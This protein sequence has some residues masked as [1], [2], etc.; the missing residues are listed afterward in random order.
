MPMSARMTCLRFAMFAVLAAGGTSARADPYRDGLAAWVKGDFVTAVRI[1]TPLADNGDPAAQTVLGGAYVDGW[2]VEKDCAKGL[3]LLS[4][5]A[6]AGARHAEYLM[7]RLSATGTCVTKSDEDALFHYK[8]AAAKHDPDAEFEIGNFYMTG[9][10]APLD[11]IEAH[12]WLTLCVRD[13]KD[14]PSYSRKHVDT[15][16]HILDQLD[17]F[18]NKA[19][20]TRANALADAT[21]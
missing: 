19:D 21:K 15:A 18:L 14:L 6:Q 13:G 10:G 1:L 12:R 17:T 3:E 5:A 9:R 4:K 16:Q 20:I 8:S 11:L 2:G 7:G